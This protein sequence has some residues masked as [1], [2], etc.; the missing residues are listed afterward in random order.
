MKRIF[1]YHCLTEHLESSLPDHQVPCNHPDCPTPGTH[2][3]CKHYSTIW[4]QED[5][6]R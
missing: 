6:Q 1:C 2:A 4:E 3:H 5:S